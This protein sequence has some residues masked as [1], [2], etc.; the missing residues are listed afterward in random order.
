MTVVS[1]ASD[2]LTITRNDRQHHRDARIGAARSPDSAGCGRGFWVGSE[3]GR[4][5]GGSIRSPGGAVSPRCLGARVLLA[6][7]SPAAEAGVARRSSGR[8]PWIGGID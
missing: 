4:R 5:Y 1:L 7:G 8:L 3:A 6:R 2:V